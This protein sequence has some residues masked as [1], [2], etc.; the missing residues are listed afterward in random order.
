MTDVFLIKKPWVT[1]KST[2]L[3]QLG[4]Y[5][6]IVKPKATKQEV[7]KAVKEIYKVDAVAVNVVNRPPKRKRF[8]ANIKGS[9]EGYRKAIVTLKAGQKI[10]IQ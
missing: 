5:V 8:G 6:F 1:E 4:K 9:Q 3:A 2:G 10:D 7:K